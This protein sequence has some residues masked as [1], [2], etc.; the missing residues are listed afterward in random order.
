MYA[1]VYA[2]RTLAD[3]SDKI[4]VVQAVNTGE[5]DCIRAVHKDADLWIL[6]LEQGS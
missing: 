3:F 6:V 5:V 4:G 1:L 2:V